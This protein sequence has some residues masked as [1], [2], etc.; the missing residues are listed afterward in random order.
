ML[1][2]MTRERSAGEEEEVNV[3]VR[4]MWLCVSGGEEEGRKIKA[5]RPCFWFAN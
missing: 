3:E 4:L 2:T 5:F 1:C